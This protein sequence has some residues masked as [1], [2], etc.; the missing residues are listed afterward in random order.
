[1][2]N[3]LLRS[4][5]RHGGCGAALGAVLA[6]AAWTPAQ[7]QTVQGPV[8][9]LAFTA[10]LRHDT[11]VAR[12]DEARAIARG[13]EQEDQRLSLGASLLLARP[14]GRNK[15]SVDAFVGYDFY[16]RNTRLNR[17]RISFTGDLELNAGPCTANFLPR[18]SRQQSELYELAILNVPGVDS[19][20]NT[21]TRQVYRGELRCGNP[22][23]IRPLAHYER[24]YGD[25]S[26]PLREISDYRG[27]SFGG[28]LS[29]TNP[30][31]GEFD[32]SL[33]RQNIRYPNRPTALGLTGFRTDQIRLAT[34][35]NIGAVLTAEGYVAY[36]HLKPR[37]S[38]AQDFK[39]ASWSLALTAVPLPNLQL[40]ANL[41]QS[42]NPSLSNNALYSRDR[43]WGLQGTYQFGPKTSLTLRGSRSERLYRGASG[44][45]GPLLDR[46]VLNRLSARISFRP[47]QRLTFGLDGGHEWRNANGTFYDYTNT[48]AAISARFSLGTP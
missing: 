27:E 8:N 22:V 3:N 1:M 11:N 30:I 45:L 6:G 16:R 12:A 19:V 18:F 46:D 41:S 44:A 31:L 39:G 25:N 29:Y 33:E 37:N 14:L 2:V 34:S 21:E 15:V 35:R 36:T 47:S 5:R 10:E 24:S 28:G 32:L 20:R 43:D 17:E 4:V 7:A 42:V 13:V 26:N 9:E 38:G 23:G 40:R 48:Y